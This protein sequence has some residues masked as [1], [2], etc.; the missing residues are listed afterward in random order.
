MGASNSVPTLMGQLIVLLEKQ[1]TTIKTKT[2]QEF[3]KTVLE[4]SPW[5]LQ[6]GGLIPLTVNR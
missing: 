4:F 3:I 2:A 1:G 5:F 6:A